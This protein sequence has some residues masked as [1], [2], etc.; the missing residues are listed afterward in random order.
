MTATPHTRP[1]R[2]IDGWDPED[3]RFWERTG[4]RVARRN[5]WLSILSE[6]IGFSVWSVW[7]VMV[8]FMSPAIG[9]DFDASEKFLLTT[10]PNLV[11]ALLRL[12]YSY[13]VTRFG[14]R[15]W[16]VLSTSALLVP[17][18]LTCYFV[19]QPGTPL[20]VFLLLGALTGIGGGNF[21]SSMT[22]ITAFFPQRSQGWALGL[23]AGGGNIGV[24]VIQLVGLLVI[25]T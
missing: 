19:Q 20:G 21:A 4:R 25:A 6:H 18:G 10:V 9:L 3:D 13:A 17:T 11:G 5:L 24:A 22:N 14:G 1:G 2:W 12:P 8:L 16:T 15:N 23:N 7:S